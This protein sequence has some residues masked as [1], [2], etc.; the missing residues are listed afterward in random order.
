MWF[1]G[2]ARLWNINTVYWHTW[3]IDFPSSECNKSVLVTLNFLKHAQTPNGRSSVFA[4]HLLVMRCERSSGGQ[5]TFH[6][7]PSC[8]IQVSRW[9]PCNDCDVVC[10]VS[11]M[12]RHH[13]FMV[14]IAF[15][16]SIIHWFPKTWSI[17]ISSLI[18][19]SLFLSIRV[20]FSLQSISALS[21]ALQVRKDTTKGLLHL[22][23]LGFELTAF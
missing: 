20:G 17:I 9:R 13:S 10:K 19:W 15:T 2:L 7:L 11:F 4:S 8:W 18:H 14:W 23:V 3:Q 12:C 22:V 16:S 21:E 5:V 6:Y 1:L